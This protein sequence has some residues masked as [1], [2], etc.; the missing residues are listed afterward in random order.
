MYR[1]LNSRGYKTLDEEQKARRKSSPGGALLH[2]RPDDQDIPL[3]EII[4]PLQNGGMGSLDD[5]LG[6]QETLRS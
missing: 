2:R 5:L 4:A 6:E 1:L 3:S